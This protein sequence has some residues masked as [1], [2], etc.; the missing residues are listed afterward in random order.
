MGARSM[1]PGIK[2]W[3]FHFPL[4]TSTS[5]D[6]ILTSGVP[7]EHLCPAGVD[8][9]SCRAKQKQSYERQLYQ[10]GATLL[11]F[12]EAQ[13]SLKAGTE[14]RRSLEQLQTNFHT[15]RG[16]K[17]AFFALPESYQSQ[18]RRELGDSMLE[19]LLSIGDSPSSGEFYS[20]L[21]SLA[22]HLRLNGQAS[23]AYVIFDGLAASPIQGDIGVP[24][25]VR[26]EAEQAR[27]AYRGR[28][29][30]GRRFENFLSDNL[31]LTSSRS[32]QAGGS[33][34]GLAG[35]ACSW[36]R[37]LRPLSAGILHLLSGSRISGL[38]LLSGSYL[39]VHDAPQVFQAA[40]RL[41]QQEYRGSEHS[42]VSDLLSLSGFSIA[43]LGLG[44][45]FASFGLGGRSFLKAG[46]EV[47]WEGATLGRAYGVGAIRGDAVRRAVMDPEIWVQYAMG[48]PGLSMAQRNFLA[49]GG[50]W[51]N[52]LLLK[53]SAALGVARLAWGVN[54][55]GPGSP[56]W[57]DLMYGF[58]LDVFPA[59]NLR[60]YRAGRG[61]RRFG[62]G[63]SVSQELLERHYSDPVLRR[64]SANKIREGVGSLGEN[65]EGQFH[66][67]ARSDLAAVER[68]LRDAK[69]LPVLKPTPASDGPRQAVWSAVSDDI[70]HHPPSDSPPPR[71]TNS[72][73]PHLRLQEA[74]SYDLGRLRR[75]YEKGEFTPVDFLRYA[76]EHP[77]ARHGSLFPRPID[78]GS[79]MSSLLKLANESKRRFSRGNPR[80][81]E[82][83][84]VAVKDIF[85]GVDGQMG[86][87]SKTAAVKGIE[88]SPVV[89]MLIQLG[90][91]P[92]P[93][94]MTAQANGGSGMN[95]GYGY[96]PHP[97]R[98]GFDPAG[99]SSAPAHLIGL[100]DFPVNLGIGTDT[101]GSITAPA[102]AVGLFGFV[103]SAGILSTKNMI[104]FAT[105]LDR[106]G[107]LAKNP[108]DGMTLARLLSQRV[109]DDPHM[110]NQNPASQYHP[111]VRPPKIVYLEDLLK[112][113]SA[114]ARSHFL[115]Q[116]EKY[117]R[118]GIQIVPLNSSW[119]FL[120][121]VPLKL[122]PYDA[123]GAAIFTHANPLQNRR[124]D[125]PRRTLDDNLSVR[126]PKGVA[127]L[128][129]GYYDRAR[130]SSRRYLNLVRSKLG[131]GVVLASPAPEAIPTESILQGKAGS[132]LDLHDKIT[133]AKNRI[134]EWGQ[135]TLPK[136]LHSPFGI[137]VSGSLPDLAYFNGD[138]KSG[139]L[140]L[141]IRQAEVLSTSTREFIPRVFA[142]AKQPKSSSKFLEEQ[143]PD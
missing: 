77:A 117:R 65:A 104:P 74:A 96:I 7:Q 24:P 3:P 129:S 47:F 54:Q 33:I 48:N 131:D 116:M 124:L 40:R 2:N 35:I 62:V 105:F 16:F 109:G 82:G 51:A 55:M 70:V 69:S 126:L 45:G 103:P 113:V 26:R 6:G 136:R 134:P 98:I 57:V 10:N 140:A 37:P 94:G 128:E 95:A 23:E 64:V 38:F 78:Q 110:P 86:L 79:L 14:T 115:G 53:G 71:Q 12:L 88:P 32:F 21:L 59:V 132:L 44:V 91:I 120:A 80:P 63:P 135:V 107:I 68:L 18:L 31:L 122:Y 42:A 30:H 119:N 36:V 9:W 52:R 133:M 67:Q 141:L 125:P 4:E 81:L 8:N 137:A 76:M 127:A 121:E 112:E 60:L 5:D 34:L 102:G 90:A 49:G 15:H 142:R 50:I 73:M 101:G 123:Y 41:I 66:A 58:A 20:N 84:L 17:K 13:V 11:K 46:G 61:D 85:P 29:S 19:R 100:R 75:A 106:V 56:G 143:L 114:E 22:H 93:V 28:G 72:I 87:G 83:V 130:E 43:T 111:S 89:E 108:R 27:E 92:I 99:S 97:T 138:L 39:W 1:P 118:R 139:Q 25:V